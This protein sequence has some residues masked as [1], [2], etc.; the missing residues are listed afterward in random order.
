M[1]IDPLVIRIIDTVTGESWVYVFQV[2][3]VRIGC[4]IDSSLPIARPFISAQHGSFVFDDQSVRYQDLDPGAG[5]RVDGVPPRG[6]ETIVSDWTSIQMGDLR[7]TTSRRLPDTAIPDPG[8]SPFARPPASARRGRGQR[9][10]D[11]PPTA[12]PPRADRPPANPRAASSHRSRRPQAV[13]RPPRRRVKARFS[14]LAWLSAISLGVAVVAVLGLVL[15]FRV[16][17]WMPPE[18][19]SRIPPWLGAWFQDAPAGA[20]GRAAGA[21]EEASPPSPRPSPRRTGNREGSGRREGPR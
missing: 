20:S 6:R 2:G 11:V 13:E 16:V 1:V 14:I 10:P 15:Q 19:V 8:L 4:D 12:D 21:R 3:P 9:T 18:L 5:T 17:P 7:I